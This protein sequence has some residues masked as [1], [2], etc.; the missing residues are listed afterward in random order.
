MLYL[1]SS[2]IRDRVKAL[3]MDAAFSRHDACRHRRTTHTT[4]RQSVQY[5]SHRSIR[6]DG[7]RGSGQI[8]REQRAANTCQRE[9]AS[10]TDVIAQSLVGTKSERQST[11]GNDVA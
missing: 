5:L 7:L 1:E 4:T 3:D 6:C 10:T 8:L 2:G 11:I 9:V